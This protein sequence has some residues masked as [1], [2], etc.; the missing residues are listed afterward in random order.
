MSCIDDSIY[1]P[2]GNA[3]ISCIY[4]DIFVI[5][6]AARHNTS[7]LRRRTTERSPRR[8]FVVVGRGSRPSRD[9]AASHRHSCGLPH[10]TRP[11]RVSPL[12]RSLGRARRHTHDARYVSGAATRS[13]P[14]TN[15][16]THTQ[17]CVW[18][19]APRRSRRSPRDC[20]G[21]ARACGRSRSRPSLSGDPSTTRKSV[22]GGWSSLQSES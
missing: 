8:P 18:R 16:T 5:R 11:A 3:H 17:G 10:V 22:G 2:D 14:T 21:A 19:V 6:H 15:T 4:Y 12:A 7:A 1:F 9:R 13:F 20:D